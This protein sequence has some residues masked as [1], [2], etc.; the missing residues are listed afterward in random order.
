[1]NLDQIFPVY[2]QLEQYFIDK[3]PQLKGDTKILAGLTKL[4]EEVGELNSDTLS[5]IG[6]Q[7][8]EKAKTHQDLAGEWADVF[9]A[10]MMFAVDMDID[11]SAAVKTKLAKVLERYQLQT[12]AE[13]KTKAQFELAIVISLLNQQDQI[14]MAKRAPFKTHAANVWENI[15]GAVEAGE[16][17][18]DTLKREIKEELGAI[19]YQIIE[20]YNTFKTRLDNGREIIGISYL[21]RYLDG[22]ITLNPEHTEYKWVN[23]DEAIGLTVTPGLKQ[24]LALL[25]QKILQRY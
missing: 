7:R 24:E 14:L 5:V 16:S 12:P 18:L 19:N 17:P 10:L 11:P 25:K 3:Y 1:M 15:S 4:T 8:Q 2:Q 22:E 23:L 13:L 20:P 6:L 21:C 9:N